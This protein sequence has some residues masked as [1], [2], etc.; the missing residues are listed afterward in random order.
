MTFARCFFRTLVWRALSVIF[1]LINLQAVCSAQTYSL[2]VGI[3]GL[4]P[5]G[6]ERSCADQLLRYKAKLLRS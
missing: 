6:L 2:V 3:D 5:Y 4:G 1:L